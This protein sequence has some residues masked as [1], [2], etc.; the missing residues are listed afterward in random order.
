MET[1]RQ[2]R[3]FAG[4]RDRITDVGISADGKWLLSS[5]M[6]GTLR[7]WDIPA[8]RTLQ[9]RR[10]EGSGMTAGGS[11]A[12]IYIVCLYTNNIYEIYLYIYYIL[13]YIS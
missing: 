5:S 13:Y 11:A 9:V 6:D 2:V 8:A 7:V 4:H 1:G 10:L 3:S 12:L